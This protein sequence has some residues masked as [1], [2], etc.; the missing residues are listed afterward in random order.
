MRDDMLLI[1]NMAR[2]IVEKHKRNVENNYMSSNLLVR[3]TDYT[4][5]T[6]VNPA[7][8]LLAPPDQTPSTLLV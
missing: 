7:S 2:D 8:T 5:S 1:Q 6:N 3:T 4:Q